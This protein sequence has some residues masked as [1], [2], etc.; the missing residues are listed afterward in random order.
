MEW[1]FLIIGI[2]FFGLVTLFFIHRHGQ[3]FSK[4]DIKWF[5][6]KWDDVLQLK[7]QDPKHA[8]IEADKLLDWV[9]SKK[10]YGGSLGEKLKKS[11]RLF[12]N[13]DDVWEAHKKRNELVHEIDSTLSLKEVSRLLSSYRLAFRDLGL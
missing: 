13:L 8:L 11:G 6:A 12:S 3:K 9:L 10:G 7:F 1:T 2:V 4:H 5:H